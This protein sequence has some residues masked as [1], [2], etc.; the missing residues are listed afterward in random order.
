MMA[1]DERKRVVRNKDVVKIYKD[2]DIEQQLEG[3]AFVWEVGEGNDEFY[4][5]LVFF[6]GDPQ[7]R[8]VLRKYRKTE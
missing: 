7:Q 5:L 2:P 8:R 3:Y 6:L 4:E 1:G